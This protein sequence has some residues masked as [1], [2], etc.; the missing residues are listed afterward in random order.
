PISLLFYPPKA[1]IK[2]T[3]IST[4]LMVRQSD[5]IGTLDK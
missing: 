3:I 4:M 5:F 1:P 2:L